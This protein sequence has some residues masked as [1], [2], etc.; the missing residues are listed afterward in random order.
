MPAK[1]NSEN[2][3]VDSTIDPGEQ[4]SYVARIRAL[5]E[6]HQLAQARALLS[7]APKAD[8]QDPTL[9]SLYEVLKPPHARIR[10]ITDRDR[11]EEFE[12]IV[13]NRDAYRGRW[14]AVQGNRLVADAPSFPEL[15]SRIQKLKNPPLVHRID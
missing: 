15:Q 4:A 3:A 6:Q 2:Q 5:I 7:Q 11:T 12:W 1:K 8:G 10:K 13:A 9:L 14:V